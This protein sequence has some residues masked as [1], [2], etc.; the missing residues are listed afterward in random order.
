MKVHNSSKPIIEEELYGK[1]CN[2][3]KIFYDEEDLEKHKQEANIKCSRCSKCMTEDSPDLRY[4]YTMEHFGEGPQFDNI[5][6]KFSSELSEC[7]VVTC[8]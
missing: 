2:C 6:S 5:F 7:P 3:R 4:C 8:Y 1:P